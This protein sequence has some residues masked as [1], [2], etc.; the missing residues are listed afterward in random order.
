MKEISMLDPS[1]IKYQ[2]VKDLFADKMKKFGG[3]TLLTTAEVVMYLGI[4]KQAFYR[5]CYG[6]NNT[7]GFPKPV[8]VLSD[9]RWVFSEIEDWLFTRRNQIINNNIKGQL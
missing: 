5:K 8:S 6:D 7:E 9:K 2:E 3:K 1:E 4:S